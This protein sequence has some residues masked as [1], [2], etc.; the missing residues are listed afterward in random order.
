MKIRLIFKAIM[1]LMLAAFLNS[2]SK[3][4]DDGS[5]AK[6]GTVVMNS[7]TYTGVCKSVQDVGSGGAQ[8][9]IDVV[10][11][12]TSGTSFAI[13]NMPKQSS[14][15]YTFT[16]GDNNAGGSQLY[17]LF[18]LSSGTQYA[19]T[20]GTITKT[21]ASSFNFSCTMYDILSNTTVS[22]TGKGSY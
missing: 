3:N 9:N 4:N 8:G 22:V 17:A 15:T 19:T 1:F 11:A 6:S 7:T 10:I 2:C 18:T 12:T 21:G 14:G 13:Y 5:Q 20:G 16:N